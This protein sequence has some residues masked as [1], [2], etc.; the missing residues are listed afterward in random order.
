[1][2][3]LHHSV[4]DDEADSNFGFC[5]PWWDRLLGTYRD[6]PRDVCRLPGLLALPFRDR[7]KA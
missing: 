6:Q 4:E 7:T 2:H 5:V 3:R 1:M